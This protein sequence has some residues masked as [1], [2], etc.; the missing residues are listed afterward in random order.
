MIE[1]EKLLG[2]ATGLF[3]GIVV[4]SVTGLI[5]TA[6]SS[7]GITAIREILV[8]GVM[9]YPLWIGY[10]LSSEELFGKLEENRRV[11]I[12][13]A[14]VTVLYNMALKFLDFS[15]LAFLRQS[16]ASSFFRPYMVFRS[17]FGLLAGDFLYYFS[18]MYVEFFMIYVAVSAI[19]GGQ[20]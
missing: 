15:I 20:R 14:G 13:T 18:I 1:Y 9:L 19:P 4:L 17:E 6:L 5:F 12:A 3:T 2:P 8:S 11:L 7:P 10:K 16:L